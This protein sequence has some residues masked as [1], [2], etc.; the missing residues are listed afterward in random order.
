MITSLGYFTIRG[1]FYQNL[2]SIINLL[3]RKNPLYFCSSEKFSR[4]KMNNKLLYFLFNKRPRT[5]RIFLHNL[6]ILQKISF[7]IVKNM[8]AF[9]DYFC[10]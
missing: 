6:L 1:Y 4:I 10:R 7:M 8:F 9:G 2:V 5:L 3:R